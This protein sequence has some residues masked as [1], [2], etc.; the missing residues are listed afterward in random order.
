MDS[1]FIGKIKNI[2]DLSGRVAVVTG[3]SG[4]LGQ[5]ITSSLV[6]FGAQVVLASRNIEKLKQLEGEIQKLGGKAFAIGT[7]IT[8]GDQVDRM[9]VETMKRFEKIDIL[10]NNAGIIHRALAE[11]MGLENWQKVIETN[12]TGSFLCS[13]RVGKAMIPRKRGKI[14]NISSVRGR[15]GRPK[16]FVAY[17]ASKGGIDSLTRALA[18]EWGKYNIQVNAIAPSLI[19]GSGTSTQSLK[20]PTYTQKLIEKIPLGRWG[21]P[22]DLV[23]SVVF[24]AS[25]ASNFVNGHILYVDGG[26]AVSA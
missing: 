23:G 1:Q 5:I 21:Q 12:V 6:A 20:D 7:D 10:V 13:Q 14:V 17:C 24:L 8:Q 9:V 4:S 19:E 22:E 2:F 11:E 26:Y 16:D 15:F 18:C 25:D 3:A